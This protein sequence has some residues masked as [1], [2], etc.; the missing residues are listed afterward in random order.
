[1]GG[2]YTITILTF[3]IA[4]ILFLVIGRTLNNMSNLLIKLEYLLVKEREFREEALEVRRIMLE[5][6]RNETENE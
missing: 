5:Q 6:K 4:F 1:M 2:L 3:I